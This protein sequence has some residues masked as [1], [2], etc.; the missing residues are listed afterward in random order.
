MTKRINRGGLPVKRVRKGQKTQVG[1][2][3]SYEARKLLVAAAKDSGRSI[4]RQAE[5]EIER[6][7]AFDKVLAATRSTLEQMEGGA[8]DAA[9]LRMGY[10]PIRD[11]ATG[12][13]AWLEPGYPGIQRSGFE[14]WEPGEAAATA[15]GNDEGNAEKLRRADIGPVW[16]ADVAL[17][18]LDRIADPPAKKDDVA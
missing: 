12:K 8:V 3:M 5:H 1:V 11:A 2:I 17:Q 10:V 4:S 15:G 13:K 6:A 9:L 7:F 16:D 14:G 18:R